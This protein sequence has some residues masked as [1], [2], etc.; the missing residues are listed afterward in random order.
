VDVELRREGELLEVAVAD[1]GPGMPGA[2][3]V[4]AFDRGA[5]FGEHPGSS[6]LGLWIVK[7]L[8]A[9]LGGSVR[10]EDRPGGGLVVRV[11]L[12]A[13]VPTDRE[14]RRGAVRL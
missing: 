2:V 8:T 4:R 6:G 3:A 9:A 7:E 13:Q 10:A 11:R 1:R 5:S 14:Q 12:P